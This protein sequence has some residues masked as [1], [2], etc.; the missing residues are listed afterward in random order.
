MAYCLI[1]MVSKTVP[2]NNNK[3]RSVTY[4]RSS[5]HTLR[6]KRKW[7]YRYPRSR[8]GGVNEYTLAKRGEKSMVMSPAKLPLRA[9]C[10]AFV[11]SEQLSSL[12]L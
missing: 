7:K 8:K 10:Y 9:D 2:L 5:P 12:S 3:F 11:Y 4:F 1:E 6:G